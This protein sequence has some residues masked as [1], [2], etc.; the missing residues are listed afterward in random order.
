MGL[1]S[2]T[3]TINVSSV[4]YNMAG[5]EN[6]RPNFLKGTI[7]GSVIGNSPSLADDLTGAHFNGPGMKQRQF[8]RWADSVNMSG[9]PSAT[10]TNSIALDTSIVGGEIPISPTPVGLI[11]TCYSA[12]VSEGNPDAWLERWI[13]ENHPTRIGEDWLGDYDPVTN[14]FSVEF[15]NNDFFSWSNVTAP[16]YDPSKR[17]VV[18]KYIETTT[19]SEGTIVYGTPTSGV[20]TL[21]DLTGWTLDGSTGSFTT[22][23]LVRFRTTVWTYSDATPPAT[24]EDNVS[25]DVSGNL[26]TSVDNYSREVPVTNNGI[27]VEGERQFWTFTGTDSITNDYE[28]V[29]VT[30]TDMG[31]GVTRTETST[32]TG[33]QVTPSWT[34]QYDTQP[35]F[36]GQVSGYEQVFLYEVGTGNTTLDTLVD[37]VDT[38]DLQ[39]FFPFMPLRINNV[40][41]GE[42]MYDSLRAEMTKGYKRAFQG[43]KFSD[44]IALVE[45]NPSV[46]DIDYA[47]LIFGVSLNVKEVSCKKYLYNFFETLKTYQSAGSSGAIAALN[48]QIASYNTALSDLNVWLSTDWGSSIWGSIP[49]RPAIPAITPPAVNTI[50]LNDSSLGFDIR[51]NWID[52]TTDQI[53]GTYETDPDITSGLV[54]PLKGEFHLC[55]GADIVYT[56]RDSYNN[57][58]VGSSVK[59][60]THTIP[61]MHIYWQVD[62]NSYRKM[63]IY[64]L[65][66]ENYI[67][68]G[69]SVKIT[70]TEAL[71]DTD[72]SGFVVPL[73]YPTFSAM[74]IVDYTQMATANCH[75]MFNCYTVTVQK[76]YEKLIFKILLLILIIVVAVILSPGSFAA[77]GGLLGGNLA[78]GAA[79]G[80][81]GT[82]AIV[83]G[84][85]ANYIASIIVSEVLKVVGTALFGEKWGAVFAAIAGFALGAAISGVKLW[86]AEGLLGLGNAVANGYA[87]WTQ[88]NIAEMGEALDEDREDY[89]KRMD[90]IDGLIRGLGGNDLNFNPLFL[91]DTGRRGNGRGSSGYMPETAD[92]YIRRTTMTGSDIV[93]LTHSMVYDFV[94]VSKTLPRN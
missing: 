66:H 46:D 45:D 89:E 34:S 14:S 64:G 25:A 10:I 60:T 62:D 61:S 22:S 24:V 49:T 83:A 20:L 74:G 1:F 41:V 7:F 87:G 53:A 26:N 65:V 86:S 12:N 92:E 70:S 54:T 48:S 59:E 15:P 11:L 82:A 76:W 79:L 36:Y 30:Y 77:G 91:T 29:Q 43:K 94:D 42:S 56:E 38:S 28:D 63:T 93:E 51:L 44:L 8:F 40:S 71:A 67:Y 2:D 13:L 23:N 68:G 35:I 88:A 57:Y 84:V 52:I 81:T 18:G 16:V 5:D 58:A 31:G 3:K 37:S 80:L 47:Y 4:L 85:V 33:E 55:V 72:E 78:V 39:E 73:H 75:I 17:Y 50:R 19:S 69:K 6:D 27:E 21:P 32:T 90:Y 9:L